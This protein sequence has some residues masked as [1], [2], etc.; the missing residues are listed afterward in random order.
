[1]VHGFLEMC[2]NFTLCKLHKQMNGRSDYMLDCSTI[3]AHLFGG[4]R[5]FYVY[6]RRI[7]NYLFRIAALSEPRD[8]VRFPTLV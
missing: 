8:V 2:A 1:M 4:G 7:C 6:I 5:F 3:S